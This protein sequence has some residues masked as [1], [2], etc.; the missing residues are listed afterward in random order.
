MF[1][2]DYHAIAQKYGSASTQAFVEAVL[3]ARS[4]LDKSDV[5]TIVRLF[6]PFKPF[7]RIR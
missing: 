5:K 7:V 6:I 3:R 2:L 1:Y 4:D